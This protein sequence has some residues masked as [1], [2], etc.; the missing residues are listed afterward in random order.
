FIHHMKGHKERPPCECPL[1]D[2]SYI[3]VRALLNHL[4]WHAGYKLYQ[5]RFCTFFSIYF[6][7]MV[8][9]SSIHTGAEP[10]FCEF[11]HSAFAST[12]GLQ[13]HGRLH[14]GKEACQGQQQLD[15]VRE[16]R[17]A[18]RALTKYTKSVRPVLGLEVG[19]VERSKACDLPSQPRLH[20]CAE[21]VYATS[22][23]SNLQLH[24]RIHTGE[25]PYSCSLCQRRFRTSSHLKRHGL[26]NQPPVQTYTCEECGYS[27]ACNGNLKLHL[28]IHMGEK[29][30]R[31]GQCATAF[32]TSSHLKWHLLTY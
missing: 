23:S 31:C 12:T 18:P 10:Y 11:C 25:K 21:C 32:R 16:G 17:R 27:T 1:C 24:V 30:F 5:C 6:A 13:R 9:H 28:R 19:G 7:S 3:S 22:Q 14:M 20:Q 26:Q 4:Y 8:R 29:P 15:F 2:Y